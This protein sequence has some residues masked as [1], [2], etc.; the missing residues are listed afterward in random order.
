MEIFYTDGFTFPLFEGSSFPIEKYAL[1]RKRIA[2]VGI[3]KPQ[4]MHVPE[5][6]S[7]DELLR[8]HEKRYLEGVLEG[9]L[10]RK[11]FRRI[12][13]PWSH[14]WVERVKR[15][16]GATLQSARQALKD[17]IAV[18]LAGGSHH[19]FPDRGEGYCAFNDCAVAARAMQAEG[20]AQRVIIVDCDVHQGNGTASIF[21]G[22]PTVFTFSIHAENNFPSQ[23]EHSDLDIPLEDRTGNEKYLAALEAGLKQALEWA[24]ADLAFFIAGADPYFDDRYG[25]LSLSKAGLAER[26]RMVFRRCGAKGIPVVVTM[27]GGYARRI[28]DTVDIHFQTVRS[29][30]K[31]GGQRSP[32]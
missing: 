17:G 7:D 31:H 29:A 27:G 26:D 32:Q 5:P 16:C 4:A 28:Q 11:E 8:V 23:K 20:L 3:I 2:K 30:L 14:E 1:L 25:G 6:A 12:G 15:S 21:A 10:T 13:F 9:T 24:D 18:N 19:A 22:D